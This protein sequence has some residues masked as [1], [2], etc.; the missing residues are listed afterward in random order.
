MRR[1]QEFVETVPCA[2]C[3]GIHYGSP[4]NHCPYTKAPCVVCKTMTIW[5]CSDCAIDSGGKE[6]VHVCEKVECQRKHEK[7]HARGAASPT[8][9]ERKGM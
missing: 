5:A 8:L 7:K 9:A 6:S 3:G 2:N 1:K 4:S